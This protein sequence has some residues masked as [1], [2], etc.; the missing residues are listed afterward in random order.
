MFP[1]TQKYKYYLQT[2]ATE[3]NRF[4]FVLLYSHGGKCRKSPRACIG[5]NPRQLECTHWWHVRWEGVYS[6]FS[7]CITPFVILL[8]WS[9]VWHNQL[10]IVSHILPHRKDT[11]T[12]RSCRAGSAV[13]GRC[14]PS[15][16][17][18]LEHKQLYS[19]GR[20][21]EQPGLSDTTRYMPQCQQ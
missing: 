4:C 6:G 14:G 3:P 16:C 17:R 7:L 11:P 18:A 10:F 2:G 20:E 9:H 1:K 13:P 8:G 12:S 5:F 19:S 15:L 21:T